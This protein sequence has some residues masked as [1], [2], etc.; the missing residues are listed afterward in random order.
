MSYLYWEAPAAAEPRPLLVFLAAADYWKSWQPHIAERGWSLVVPSPLSPT[1]GAAKALEA[2]LEDFQQR[3]RVDSRR[4]F[5]AG[6]GEGSF[7]VFYFAAR[8]P[9]LWA[10]ALAIE[11]SPKPAI[12][13]NRLFAANTQLVPV[14][15]VSPLED[16]GLKAR[17]YNLERPPKTS[18][19][20]KQAL[21]WLAAHL[22]DPFPPK[23]DCESGHPAFTRCYWVEMTK[24]DFTRRNDVLPSTR[25]PPGSGA[26]LAL[27]G[28]GFDPAQLGP[29]LLVGWLPE[30]YSGTLKLG[31]RI[32]AVGGKPIA[33]GHAYIDYMDQV[34]EQKLVMV[35]IQRG[36]ERLR[37]ETH[38]VL[39]KRGEFQTARIQAEFLTE[40][41]QLQIIS[42]GVAEVRLTLP[43]Y[44]VPCPINWN[45]LAAGQADRPG[46]WSVR[47]GAQ[48]QPCQ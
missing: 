40:F 20:S 2:I 42:R 36:K 30:N 15:W 34:K 46:C 7:A 44:W 16:Q 23:V 32:V 26:S 25:V 33:D 17:G 13:S 38:I 24:L 1:D 21:D 12:D 37:V 41:R 43:P 10:A 29:G 48:A 14:L 11:G 47:E 8:V 31:D 35:M 45:G 28:F 5:L 6:H 22:R 19:T 27:G 9:D 3:S 18:F 4:V 39:P